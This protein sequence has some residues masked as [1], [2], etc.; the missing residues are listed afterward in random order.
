MFAIIPIFHEELIS[1]NSCTAVKIATLMGF[2]AIYLSK[3]FNYFIFMMGWHQ[4]RNY[5]CP[6]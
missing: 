1:F 3:Y 2:S 5:L 4:L 6:N